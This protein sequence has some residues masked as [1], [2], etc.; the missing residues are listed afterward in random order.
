MKLAKKILI[1]EI[2]LVLSHKHFGIPFNRARVMLF[3]S[4]SIFLLSMF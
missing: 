3:N 2:L 1:N 4:P